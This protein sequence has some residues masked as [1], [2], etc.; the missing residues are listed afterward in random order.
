MTAGSG[1]RGAPLWILF[2]PGLFVLLWASGF[3]VTR[4]GLQFIEPFTLLSLRSA[5]CVALALAAMPFVGAR[6]PRGGREAAHIAVVGV[7]FQS[8]YLGCMFVALDRG[9]GQGVAALVAGMQPL[10][11]AAAVGPWLG[12][13]V[14][15]RQ[16]AGFVLGFGGV[17]CVMAE[18]V[19]AGTGSSL[20]YGAI[21][22]TP[23]LI[24]AS[25][26]YQKRFCADMDLCS[27]M[28]IQHAA[29]A[30]ASFALALAVETRTI[31]WRP[32]L[33]FVLAWM[34]LVLSFAAVNIY[35]LLLR[36]GE[37]ARVSSLFYLT[38]P[39][40]AVLGYLTYDERLSAAPLAG[41]AVEVCGVALAT[42][43]GGGRR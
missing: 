7:L 8:A 42:R 22:L 19:T 24:T 36:R 25:S 21:C 40:A 16:W 23:I 38:P 4:F 6:W 10:L 29:A 35:Y 13:R 37:A 15:R 18:R 26:L 17:A 9:V 32:E 5:L 41:F 30:S 3:P 39:A 11:T 33:G 1:R 43:A 2:A 12:E 34:V 20:G 14:S 28:A 27:G 31:D